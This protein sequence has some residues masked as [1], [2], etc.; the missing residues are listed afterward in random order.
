MSSK[1]FEEDFRPISPCVVRI[2]SSQ[3]YPTKLNKAHTGDLRAIV[4]DISENNES[5]AD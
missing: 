5:A 3:S 4:I 2:K 1:W